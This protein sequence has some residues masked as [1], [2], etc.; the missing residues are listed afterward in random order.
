MLS[1]STLGYREFAEAE[2]MLHFVDTLREFSDG[3]PV[4]IKL[5]VDRKEF[6]EI[7]YSIRK[8]ELIP[9]FIVVEGFKAGDNFSETNSHGQYQNA[10]I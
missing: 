9:D 2:S 5:C 6:H 7:C 1:L 10:F 8:T 3:K 4:G